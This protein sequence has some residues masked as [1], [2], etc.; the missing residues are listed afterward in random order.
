MWLSVG[1]FVAMPILAFT[2]SVVSI[3]DIVDRE[4]P[5]FETTLKE[6]DFSAK[7]T[8]EPADLVRLGIE[9]KQDP[10]MGNKMEGDIATSVDEKPLSDAV[11]RSTRNAIRQT[12]RRWPNGEIPYTLSSQYGSYA[13]SVIAKA[14]KEYHDKTCVRFVPRDPNRHADYVYIHPDD[15]CYSLVG[16]TG[17][18]QPLSLDSGCIQVGTIV[19]ELMHAVGFFHEQSRSD[20]DEYLDIVWSNVMKGA[21]DQF[22]KYTNSV[23]DHL[24]EPYDFSSIMHYGPY[25]FSGNGKK[26]LQPKKGNAERMG[27]RVAFSE[28]DLRKINRL[29]QCPIRQIQ[30][31]GN[32]VIE[33]QCR[34]E[35]W[36]CPFWMLYDFCSDFEE[37]RFIVCRQSCGQCTTTFRPSKATKPQKKMFPLRR[38]IIGIHFDV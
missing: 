3:K 9:V 10:T 1:V 4:R 29:Y 35:N 2:A 21:D 36:R 19:H 23:I 30:V 16:R 14:I 25:A 20:R 18:R 12:Y 31:N 13:R 33:N 24:G 32:S 7:S 8:L 26:T 5:E 27:Q 11:R 6:T 38:S 28:I 37:I 15:G 22:E 34:D 17:G